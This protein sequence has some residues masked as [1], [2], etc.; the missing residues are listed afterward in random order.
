MKSGLLLDAKIKRLV[1]KKHPD[2]EK[3]CTEG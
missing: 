1:D 2:H 3:V